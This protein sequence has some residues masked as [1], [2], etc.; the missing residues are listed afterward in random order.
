M[1]TPVLLSKL[2]VPRP[3]RDAIPRPRLIERLN[4]GVQRT[5]SLVSAPAGF[6]KSTLVAE[7]VALCGRQTAWLSVDEGDSDLSRFLIHLVAAVQTVSVGVGRDASAALQSPQPPPSEAILTALINEI[8]ALPDSMVLVLDD[9]HA[10]DAA[11]IDAAVGFLI[12]HLPQQVHLVIATREDPQLPLSRLRARDQ[13]TELRAADL[14]FT[15]GEASDFLGRV[16]GL[17]LSAQDVAALEERTEGWIAGLQLAA[18]SLQGQ[19][20]V[21]TFIQAFA[22]DH[23]YIV[24]YLVDEV[25]RSQLDDVRSFLL[26]TAI[27]ERLT[28]T[29]CDAVTG[30][31]GGASRLEALERGNFFVVPLDDRRQWYRYHHLFADVLSAHLMAEQPDRVS[32]L[33]RRASEWYERNGS[34]ADAIHH[35]LAAEDFERAADLV[36]RA[37]PAMARNRQEATLLRWMQSFPEELMQ[38]RPV[39]SVQYAGTLLVNGKLEGVE[40]RLR[41]AEL[42]LDASTDVRVGPGAP[43]A[44]M[45]VVDEEE[46]RLLPGSIAVYRAGSAMAQGDVAGTIRHAQHALALVPKTD[47]LRRGSAAALLGLAYWASGELETGHRMYAEGMDSVRMA[48]NISDAL[49]CS[50]ALADIRITQGRLHEATGTYERSLRLASVHGGPALRGTADMYVG[51]SR[52]HLERNDAQTATDLLLRSKELGPLAGLPQNPY[53]WCV[54]MANVRAAQGDLDGAVDMLTEAGQVYVGDFFPPVRPVAAM[55]ARVLAAQG[56]VHEAFSWAADHRVSADDELS[57]LREFEHLTLA[58]LLLARHRLDGLEG[59]LS[60]P[61]RL[62]ERLLKAAEEGKRTGSVIEILVL[63]S[64]AHQL[65]SDI[66]AAVN[67]LQRALGLAEPE[68]YVRMF[69]DEGPPMEELLREVAARG[70]ARE[71]SRSLLATLDGEGQERQKK[72]ALPASQLL[73]DPLSE[74]ELDVLRLL[75]SE[76]SGPEIARELVVALST[77]RTHTK[78]IYSK[79]DVTSRRAAVKRAAELGLI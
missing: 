9:Y 19:E 29:L 48:G 63:L 55:K 26:R 77:V 60:N 71:Y 68:G 17:S 14:R 53:R 15:P 27:L 13:L 23:R 76:L 3:R 38:F 36:E 32:M 61:M 66:P 35:A 8:S 64:L 43:P 33:H 47:H 42:M 30:Q 45:I 65:R 41:D 4:Q 58:R 75:R 16:M 5:M 79:L 78:S 11:P 21:S 54:A 56:R 7:W 51:M 31:K 34:P 10:V 40:A 18:L 67:V 69:V 20:D 50:I 46:F 73:V 22:G 59:S 39:L 62:L 37:G 72:A 70:A 25:L 74:R 2:F 1:V 57:Y 49:G 24:D 6:G 52:L 12:E 44:Q 28:G